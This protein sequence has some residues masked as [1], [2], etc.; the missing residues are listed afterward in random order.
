MPEDVILK[1]AE[2]SASEEQSEY[3]FVIE[4]DS[5]LFSAIALLFDNIKKYAQGDKF[6]NLA[7]YSCEGFC[8]KVVENGIGALENALKADKERRNKDAYVKAMTSLP[9]PPAD[10]EAKQ[11]VYMRQ[12]ASLRRKHGIG[13]AQKQI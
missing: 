9:E 4:K 7:R 5:V 12:V 3:A 2:E 1:D 8:E 11:L 10:D 13:G 6:G